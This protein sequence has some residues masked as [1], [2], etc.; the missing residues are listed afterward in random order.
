MDKL[1]KLALAAAL[2]VGGV[3]AAMAAGAFSNYPGVGVAANTNCTSFGNNGFCNQYQPA[4]PTAVTGS[5]TVPAD[6]NLVSQNPATITIPTSYLLSG[7]VPQ[8]V[9]AGA[10]TTVNNGTTSLILN[11]VGATEAVT[12]PASPWNGQLVEIANVT[13]VAITTFSVAA[14]AGQSLVG[15]APTALAAQTNNSA[16]IA[17]T[18]VVYRYNTANTTWY[19]VQ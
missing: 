14:N 6:T 7:G 15:V 3:A 4:G 10:A 13:A 8:V 1:K 5:E 2:L 19:R 9:T 12:M 16:A 11:G 17:L 18:R